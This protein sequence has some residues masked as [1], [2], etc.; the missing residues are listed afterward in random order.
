MLMTFNT[1]PV[2][3]RAISGPVSTYYAAVCLELRN[4]NLDLQ[5]FELKTGTPVTPALGNVQVHFSLFMSFLF[6]S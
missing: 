4:S 5:T 3:T 1:Q 2:Q 6:S